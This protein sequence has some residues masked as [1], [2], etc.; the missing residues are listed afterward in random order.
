M[1]N[2][3]LGCNSELEPDGYDDLCDNCFEEMPM[4]EW[5]TFP[6][7]PPIEEEEENA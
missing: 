3:C 4:G 7:I 1:P 2:K 5:I 6:P